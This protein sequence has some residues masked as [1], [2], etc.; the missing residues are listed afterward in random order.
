RKPLT[1]VGYA[2]PP[3]ATQFKKGQSGN[4]K[5]KPKGSLGLAKIVQES[6]NEHLT[7]QENGSR[8]RIT[9][10]RAAIKQLVNKA[11]SGDQRATKLLTDLMNRDGALPA[12]ATARFTLTEADREVLKQMV[13]RA[14]QASGGSDVE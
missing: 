5:G 11:A 2:R 13:A 14:R 10:G 9:K 4:P 6:V 12:P 1:G 3:V 8:K 7:I